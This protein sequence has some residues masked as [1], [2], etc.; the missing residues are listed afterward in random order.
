MSTIIFIK[1]YY[2]RLIL[3]KVIINYFFNYLIC[4]CYASIKFKLVIGDFRIYQFKN[5]Y[6]NN[7][8]HLIV[9]R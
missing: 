6:I 2:Y 4:K 9:N 3:I 1:G 8:N 7:H 5:Y